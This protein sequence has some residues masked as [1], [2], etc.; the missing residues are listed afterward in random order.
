M[1]VLHTKPEFTSKRYCGFLYYSLSSCITAF[2]ISFFTAHGKW[3]NILYLQTV[4]FAC[5]ALTIQP[6]LVQL[7]LSSYITSVYVKCFLGCS[8]LSNILASLLFSLFL[9]Y[10]LPRQI[11]SVVVSRVFHM[12]RLNSA[13]EKLF[14]SVKHIESLFYLFCSTRGYAIYLRCPYYSCL[15]PRLH[16]PAI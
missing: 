13:F 6:Y 2:F 1:S 9:S 15:Q 11:L 7:L 16:Y 14:F 12:M 10:F 5:L 8:H 3:F 4:L